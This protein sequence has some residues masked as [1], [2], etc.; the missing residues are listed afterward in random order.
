MSLLS[1]LLLCCYFWP[2]EPDWSADLKTLSNTDE[3]RVYVTMGALFA[4][5]T[6]QPVTAATDLCTL[7][8]YIAK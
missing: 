1:L 6:L 7:L 2:P 3:Q 5:G 8:N 4:T